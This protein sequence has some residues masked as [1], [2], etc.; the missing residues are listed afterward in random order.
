V[1]TFR[2]SFSASY[3]IYPGTN[4]TGTPVWSLSAAEADAVWGPIQQTDPAVWAIKCPMPKHW[5]APWELPGITLAPGTYTL[6]TRWTRSK[7][8]T[9]GW[10]VCVDTV[11][12][13]PLSPPPSFYPA[14][15]GVWKVTIV[16]G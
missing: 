13:E 14:G 4:T 1:N 15:S 5:L 8:V 6:V 12:G 16:V 9:D 10:H 11:T 3:A 2:R 7:P